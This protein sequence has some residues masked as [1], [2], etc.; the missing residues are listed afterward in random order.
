[1]PVP[2]RQFLGQFDALGLAARTKALVACWRDGC[3]PA[4][5]ALRFELVA[6]DRHGLEELAA[7]LD[8]HIKNVSA[9]DLF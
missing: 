6:D 1:L 3:I 5:P 2:P 8:C 7:F 4:P 9:I